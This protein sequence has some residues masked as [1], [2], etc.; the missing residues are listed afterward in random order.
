[1]MENLFELVITYQG[2]APWIIFTLLILAGMNIPI[3]IDVMIIITALLA[4]NVLPEKAMLLFFIFFFG[5]YFSAWTAF[6]IGRL[7]G[8]KLKKFKWFS[9]IFHQERLEKIGAFYEKRGFLTI[10]LGRFVPFGIRNC[11]FMTAGMSRSSFL[12]FAIYD[13]IACFTWTSTFFYFFYTLGKNY[14][15]MVKHVKIINI[16][17]FSAFAVAVIAFIWYKRTKKKKLQE[18][19]TDV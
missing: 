10:L 1:M 3:S 19:K 13:F 15:E 7:A 5:C 8:H 6:W 12:K 11:L 2:M 4:A 9:K 14:E 16:S 17:I 18:E